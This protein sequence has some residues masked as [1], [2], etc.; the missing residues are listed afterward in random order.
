MGRKEEG[1]I[2]KAKFDVAF[3]SGPVT[4]AYRKRQKRWYC[5]ALQFDLVGIGRSK[6]EAF[7]K[8]RGVVNEYLHQVVEEDGPVRFFNPS[9]GNE[10]QATEQRQYRVVA[11][12]LAKAKGTRQIPNRVDRVDDFRP[13]RECIQQ[14]DLV[15]APG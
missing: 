5:T 8:L 7:E 13:Y 12:F 1:G 6:D 9:E 3:L 2:V 10:W 11:L 15:A 4:V 14:F